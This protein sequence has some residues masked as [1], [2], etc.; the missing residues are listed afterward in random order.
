MKA[1][2]YCPNQDCDL[3]G[4]INPKLYGKDGFY[5]KKNSLLKVQR[6]QCQK[7]KSKFSENTFGFPS[8]TK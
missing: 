4:E 5:K 3:C 6:F 1:E 8:G 7:C 2:I